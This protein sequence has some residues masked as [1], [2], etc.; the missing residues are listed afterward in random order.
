MVGGGADYYLMWGRRHSAF[1]GA[2]NSM[3]VIRD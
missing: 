3:P 1:N 2:T